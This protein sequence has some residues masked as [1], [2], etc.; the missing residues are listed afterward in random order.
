MGCNDISGR[1]CWFPSFSR[2]SLLPCL[3]RFPWENTLAQRNFGSRT[4]VMGMED[5][6]ASQNP[7]D[8]NSQLYMYVGTKNYSAGATVLERNGLV[9]G[10]L[11][12]FRS[13][14]V[15]PR[16]TSRII[17]AEADAGVRV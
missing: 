9:G 7:A 15:R 14:R 3:G 6:P 4:V 10:T 11:Y 12:V 8:V 16:I 1:H 13:L 2:L 17:H 5:G